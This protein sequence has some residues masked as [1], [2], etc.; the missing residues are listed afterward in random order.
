MKH[1]RPGDPCDS[2]RAEKIKS[3]KE[4]EKKKLEGNYS[5]KLGCVRERG[6]LGKERSIAWRKTIGRQVEEVD[7]VSRRLRRAWFVFSRCPRWSRERE[8]RKEERRA[9]GGGK[10]DAGRVVATPGV[11]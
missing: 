7:E 10:S 3:R 9:A 2:R 1:P 11:Q 8:R 4:E 6:G 5:G